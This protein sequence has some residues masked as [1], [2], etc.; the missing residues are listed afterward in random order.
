MLNGVPVHH[1][2]NSPSFLLKSITTANHHIAMP[3]PTHHLE[4][5]LPRHQKVSFTA[6]LTISTEITFSELATLYLVM[7]ATSTAPVVSSAEGIV[8]RTFLAKEVSDRC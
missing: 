5:S 2:S 7:K 4:R 1:Q 8:L 6:D 3:R